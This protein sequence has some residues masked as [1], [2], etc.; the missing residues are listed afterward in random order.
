[1]R[2][3]G[4]ATVRR[5]RRRRFAVA[6]AIPAVLALAAWAAAVPVAAAGDSYVTLDQT[7]SGRTV[8]LPSQGMLAVV[9]QANGGTGYEWRTIQEPSASVIGRPADVGWPYTVSDPQLLGAPVSSVWYFP[10]AG[11]GKTIFS[12]GLFPPGVATAEETYTLT[13]VVRAADGASAGLTEPECGQIV[14]IDSTGLLGITL[15]SNA[16]TG[17]SWKVTK[18]PAAMLAA[19]PGSGDYIAPPAGSPP[20]AGGTQKFV[21]GA[22]SAGSTTLELGY[23]PPG[24]ATPDR[25]GRRLR[26][27]R[28]GR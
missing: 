9:L 10:V 1:M 22:N 16:T 21:W 3:A 14:G 17:Y 13:I 8:S 5:V 25:T 24:G 28:R 20:G 6:F 2:S 18:E 15:D 7:S 26:P 27:D 11:P 12:S 23:V 4:R 19:L